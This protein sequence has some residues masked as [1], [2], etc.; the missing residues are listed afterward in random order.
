MAVA[1]VLCPCPSATCYQEGAPLTDPPPFP[2]AYL[3]PTKSHT[4]KL[5]AWQQGLHRAHKPPPCLNGWIQA[6]G[7]PHPRFLSGVP[8]GQQLLPCGV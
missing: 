5:H 7:W 8:G 4:H 2:P 6:D 1:A 3:L